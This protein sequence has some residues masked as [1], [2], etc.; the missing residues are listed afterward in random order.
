MRLS[1]ITV[2]SSTALAPLA[3]RRVTVMGLGRHGGGVAVA[4]FLAAQGARVKVTD[5]AAAD[6]LAASLVALGNIELESLHLGGHT[7]E[8]FRDAELV[9]VNPAVRPGNAWVQQARAHG[10]E[11]TS[12]IELLLERLP[13]GVIG[14]TGSNGKSTTAAMIA[15][16]LTA[17]GHTVWLGGNNERCLLEDLPRIRP[18]DWVVLELSSFQLHWLSAAARLPDITVVTNCTPNHLDWH[19][20]FTHYVGAKRRLLGASRAAR[21]G[22][23]AGVAMLGPS[24][25]DWGHGCERDVVVAA[26]AASLPNL[27]IPGEHNRV[28]A[29]CAASAARA[30]G[31]SDTAIH[32]ALASFTG[33]PHRLEAVATGGGRRFINDTQATTPEATMAALKAIAGPIWLLCGGADKGVS[34]GTLAE[35]IVT[36]CA[37]AACYGAVGDKLHEEIRKRSAVFPM[38]RVDQLAEAVAWCWDQSSPGDAILLSPACASTDQFRD[39]AHRAEEFCTLVRGVGVTLPTQ[40]GPISNRVG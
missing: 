14:V 30:A 16:I 10:A 24:V 11:I 37:G 40:K 38:L 26:D 20:D 17:A 27:P 33:L 39:Y 8:A 18:S 13:C 25:G 29:A 35:A 3:G 32:A 28:N 4:R 12:A 19:P 31:C 21:A 6:T 34:F 1:I 22:S 36:R 23:S 9:V 15:A 5:A 2:E 7:D